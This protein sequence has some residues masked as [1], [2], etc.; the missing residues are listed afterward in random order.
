MHTYGVEVV[1]GVLTPPAVL[2]PPAGGLWVEDG[3]FALIQES[4]PAPI[5][6]N[7]LL[8]PVPAPVSSP[9]TNRTVV[10]VLND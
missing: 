10:F 2:M 3:E 4:D 9:A 7:G 8:P 6:I 5:V 1:V